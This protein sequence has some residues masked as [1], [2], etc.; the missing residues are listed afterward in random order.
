M[1]VVARVALDLARRNLDT[2]IEVTVCCGGNSTG[3]VFEAGR[4]IVY[5]ASRTGALCGGV[6]NRNRMVV[7]EV[8]AEVS[9]RTSRHELIASPTTTDESPR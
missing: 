1:W 6:I 3:R 7:S 5:S 2:V 9:D 8:H 4:M